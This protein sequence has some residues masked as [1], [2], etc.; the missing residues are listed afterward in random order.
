MNNSTPRRR[1]DPATKGLIGV[2]VGFAM[3][4][5]L[6]DVIFCRPDAEE[7]SPAQVGNP[8]GSDEDD[9]ARTFD[10][11]SGQ[12]TKTEVVPALGS[13]LSANKSAVWCG[14]LGLAWKQFETDVIKSPVR[15]KGAE[16]LCDMLNREPAAE[17]QPEHYYVAGGWYKD[18]ILDR[19]R[20]E[21]P[22]KFPHAPLPPPSQAPP[23]L[24]VGLAYAYLEV[25]FKYAAQ[26]Q[27]NREPLHFRDAAGG[28][29]DVKSFG[30]RSED[31]GDR[32]FRSQV[33]VLFREGGTFALD[34]SSGSRPYQVIVARLPTQA[35]LAGYLAELER[36]TAASLPQRL[37]ESAIVFVPTM[38]WRLQHRFSEL[39]NK[40][41]LNQLNQGSEQA[42]LE[43]VEQTIDFRMDRKGVVLRSA[44]RISGTLLNGDDHDNDPAYFLF[45][46]P[47]LVVLKTRDGRP[48]FVM[49]VAN[50]ELLYP[51]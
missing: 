42:Y 4:F 19:I 21:L 50:P 40:T 43:A 35:T 28:K 41:L 45:D 15:L 46:C 38:R 25:V 18:G 33:S 17:L 36:R 10:G 30:I 8:A 51:F 14:T 48:F 24:Q 13:P 5:A 2:I 44:A 12:L 11:P 31:K 9:L 3:L 6:A 22:S 29:T 47:Y 32:P 16:P 1:V 27:V 49:W 26:F 39:E 34:L 23:H 7:T 20:R 37:G